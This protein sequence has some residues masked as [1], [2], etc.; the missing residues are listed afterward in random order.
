MTFVAAAAFF[1]LG[2]AFL[3]RKK[4]GKAATCF[5]IAGAILI[6]H[7]VGLQIKA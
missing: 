6:G 3:F 5:M 4:K 7:L 2:W 1:G